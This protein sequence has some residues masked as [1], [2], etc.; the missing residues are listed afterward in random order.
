MDPGFIALLIP[1]L[2]LATG[3]VAV[4]KMPREAFMPKERRSEQL[5]ALAELQ[6]EVAQLR[7]DLTAT[8]E[9]LDF[10]ERLL[11]GRTA[12]ALPAVDTPRPQPPSPDQLA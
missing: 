3:F 6:E 8:Q 9:R 7:A 12:D 10:A 2:V 4:L 11:T 5:P 1:I